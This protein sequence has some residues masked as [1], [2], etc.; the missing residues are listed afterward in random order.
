M[1]DTL[2]ERNL[3]Y[4]SW[5]HI[6]HYSGNMQHNEWRARVGRI[7]DFD[8][9]GAHQF[10]VLTGLGGLREHHIL[11]DVGC[12][13]LRAGKLLIPYLDL[14]HYLGLE[15]NGE[16]ITA[17]VMH[18]VGPGLISKKGVRFTQRDDFDFYE[19]WPHVE[20]DFVLADGVIDSTN[21][22]A[23]VDALDRGLSLDRGEA[24]ITIDLEDLEGTVLRE[25]AS[26]YKVTALKPQH[27]EK[28]SWF[29]LVPK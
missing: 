29:R 5:D 14:A 18:E 10:N 9:V 21:I 24:W 25:V 28:R 6:V 11:V 7:R 27:P 19:E 26:D 13:C 22:E 1:S 20:P 2:T 15:P 4:L 17:G 3:P 8:I 16:L 12:G 23:F